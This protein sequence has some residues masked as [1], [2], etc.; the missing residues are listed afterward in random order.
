MCLFEDAAWMGGM[1]VSEHEANVSLNV[2]KTKV[3]SSN[4]E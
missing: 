4:E 1:C 2:P 3:A